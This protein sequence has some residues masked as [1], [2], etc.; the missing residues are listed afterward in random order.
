MQRS[1]VPPLVESMHLA[2][3]RSAGLRRM[4]DPA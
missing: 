4:H 3:V 1:G 2:Y